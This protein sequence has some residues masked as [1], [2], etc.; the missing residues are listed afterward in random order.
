MKPLYRLPLIICCLG[1]STTLWGQ[2]PPP[3]ILEAEIRELKTVI[4]SLRD[5]NEELKAQNA[6][7]RRQ[8]ISRP[9]STTPIEPDTPA[10]PGP[11]LQPKATPEPEAGHK[12]LYVNSHWGYLT[13]DA[14][15][16]DGI[17]VGTEGLI[18]RGNRKIGH[19]N[20]TGVKSGQ[21]V[22]DVVPESLSAPGIY[23]SAGDRIVFP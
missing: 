17:T 20:V 22:M 8:L 3:E 4:K 5:E 10:Q 23:P 13:V 9:I 16:E 2:N 18:I 15:S 21:S 6:Q 1:L 19:V 12:V 14:G 7:L 11:N